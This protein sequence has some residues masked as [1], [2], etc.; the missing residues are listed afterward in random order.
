MCFGHDSSAIQ[1]GAVIA[2][3]GASLAHSSALALTSFNNAAVVA[4]YCA[5]S[6]LARV[7]A[8]FLYIS[9][10]SGMSAILMLPSILHPMA[11]YS[12]ESCF[13]DNSV[14]K[15]TGAAASVE[16]RRCEP[17]RAILPERLSRARQRQSFGCAHTHCFGQYWKNNHP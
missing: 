17:A 14:R 1:A 9:A 4:W 10:N 15:R 8:P 11:D 12:T 7:V 3:V 13:C 5:G 16:C 6:G 2:L